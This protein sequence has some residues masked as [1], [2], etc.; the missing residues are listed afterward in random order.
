M[1]RI[2]VVNSF[3]VVSSKKTRAF[4]DRKMAHAK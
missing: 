1:V 2:I 3:A 4:L